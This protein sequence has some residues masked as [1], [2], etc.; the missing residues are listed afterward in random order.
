MMARKTDGI[1][2]PDRKISE[3]FL[4]FVAPLLEGAEGKATRK[5]FDK[6]LMVG[7][8]VW[9]SVVYDTVNGDAKYVTW[10]KQLTVDDS[11][12]TQLLDRMI[13]RKKTLFAHDL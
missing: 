12:F 2:F 8:T 11:S 9:N 13:A 10:L 7:F 4:D 1:S 5:Q 3:T 6:V